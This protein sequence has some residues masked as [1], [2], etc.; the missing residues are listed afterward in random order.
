VRKRLAERALRLLVALAAI[1]TLTGLYRS[2]GHANATTVALSFLLVVL[3]VAA[4][5]GLTEA[6]V[7]SVAATLCFNY[8]FLPPVG[9]WTIADPANWVALFA[10]LVVAIVA[11]QLSERARRKALEATEHQQETERL[12]TLSRMIL[13][14]GGSPAQV[15]GEA[16]R[17]IQEIFGAA[18][19]VLYHRGS[20]QVFRTGEMKL[21]V[22]DDRLRELVLQGNV[23]DDAAHEFVALPVSLGGKAF[24]ALCVVG[25]RLSDGARQAV[26]NLLAIALESA[27]GREQAGRVELARQSEEFKATLLDA[28]AHELKTPLTSLKAALSAMTDPAGSTSNQRELLVVAEEETDRL[29]RLVSEVLQ[30]ARLEAG[31]LRLNPK[32]SPVEEVI[33]KAIADIKGL[34]GGREV[35][36]KVEP[37]LPPVTADAELINTV[38]RC[39]LD[40]AAK[41]SSPGRPIRVTGERQEGQI[42]ISVIDHGPGL[43]EQELSLVFQ[44]YYRSAT[45]RDSVP[46]IGM[47]LAVA[48]DIVIAHGGRMWAESSPGQGSRFSFTLPVATEAVR[49]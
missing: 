36:V 8:F 42:R 2:V 23:I 13:M 5:W 15:A 39:L 47:G 49:A 33:R 45:T 29:H 27:A 22:S 43:R 26:A 11:S 37:D 28:L 9:T 12:Y 16:P 40:N 48:R 30:M 17:L 10:F 20:D 14:L 25:A 4:R 3:A 6:I 35:E 32:A 41:Y 7:T 24:G 44:K 46:G 21:P 31:K 34:L 1:G 19:V 38:L 18:G